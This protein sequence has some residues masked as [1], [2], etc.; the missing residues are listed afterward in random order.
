M[1]YQTSVYWE[2]NHFPFILLAL[3]RFTLPVSGSEVTFRFAKFAVLREAS[4]SL[5]THAV[6]SQM[7]YAFLFKPSIRPE[8]L[9]YE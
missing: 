9:E 7:L 8:P 3:P 4:A 5:S 6:Q 2:S 1:Y